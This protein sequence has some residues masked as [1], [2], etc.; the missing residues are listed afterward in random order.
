MTALAEN[1]N[2]L[3]FHRVPKTG[4]EMMQEVGKALGKLKGFRAVID[5]GQVCITGRCSSCSL[6]QRLRPQAPL[7]YHPVAEELSAF[8]S[9]FARETSK[10]DEVPVAYFRHMPHFE[11]ERHKVKRPILAGMVR[12]PVERIVSW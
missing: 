4:S 10:S 8:A 9:N 6:M 1:Q 12:H 7:M 5:P 2:V 11:W 3:V